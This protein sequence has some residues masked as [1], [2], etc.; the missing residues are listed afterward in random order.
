MKTEEE[1]I[2]ESEGKDKA[3]HKHLL[4]QQTQWIADTREELE[5]CELKELELEPEPGEE[6]IHNTQCH[7]PKLEEELRNMQVELKQLRLDR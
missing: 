4:R 2:E 5:R 3:Y 6:V 7:T 1:I